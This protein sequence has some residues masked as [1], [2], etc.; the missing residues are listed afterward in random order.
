MAGN[1]D[2]RKPSW[3]SEHPFVNIAL[4]SVAAIVLFILFLLILG[5]FDFRDPTFE[6]IRS[7]IDPKHVTSAIAM[8]GIIPATGALV[9]K[10]Q[11]E[12]R[13]RADELRNR[14]DEERKR[15]DEERKNRDERRNEFS[16]ALERIGSGG[17]AMSRLAGVHTLVAAADKYPKEYQDETVRILC[18]YL[19]SYHS[20]DDP[21]I[22]SAV[23]ES[24]R[25]HYAKDARPSWSGHRLDLHGATIGN[26]FDFDG[27]EFNETVNLDGATFEQDFR[28]ADC[29][30]ERLTTRGTIFRQDPQISDPIINES[31]DIRLS[32]SSA[33]KLTITRGIIGKI[34]I[35]DASCPLSFDACTVKSI[36]IQEQ[37]TINSINAGRG[38]TIES[39]N[40]HN[41]TIKL[42]NAGLHGTIKLIN[43]GRYGTIGSIK[44][45]RGTIES[46][47]V[48]SGFIESINAGRY[49]TIGSIG[50]DGGVFGSIGVG[51]GTIG[52]IDIQEL[53]TIKSI[54]IQEHGYVPLIKS[55]GGI[56]SLMI[57]GGGF[58]DELEMTGGVIHAFYPSANNGIR[59][60]DLS[61]GRVALLIKPQDFELDVQNQ[62]RV[63]RTVSLMTAITAPVLGSA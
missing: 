8:L 32:G 36:D 13:N 3:L 18:A 43:A 57:Y 1:K 41:G 60:L 2:Q 11:D 12:L 35:F 39:I 37:G 28:L 7:A 31:W 21:V 10:Y 55:C 47:E 22:E 48:D 54:K 30:F 38:G 51:P 45:R 24:L 27:C 6:S 56:G 40:A 5:G 14:A 62:N 23:L 4:W 42:I 52:S 15:A 9:L 63:I 29:S 58:V 26:P 53:G 16:A 44:V 59:K 33:E 19:R 46:I 17:S 50:V 34:R 49:G 61:G 20:K 25:N